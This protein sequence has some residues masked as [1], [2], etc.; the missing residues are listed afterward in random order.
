MTTILPSRMIPTCL[1]QHWKPLCA[2]LRTAAPESEWDHMKKF[3]GPER[4]PNLAKAWISLSC[5]CSSL[6]NPSHFRIYL[7][8]IDDQVW[9]SLTSA[10]LSVS[11]LMTFS[12]LVSLHLCSV[13]SSSSFIC[14]PLIW[15]CTESCTWG[16]QML[17]CSIYHAHHNHPHHHC[18]YPWWN[19]R[20]HLVL[21]LHLYKVLVFFHNLLFSSVHLLNKSRCW[22][23]LKIQGW[24]K[25]FEPD[26]QK[27]EELVKSITKIQ[28]NFQSLSSTHLTDD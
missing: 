8:P 1:P 20:Y 10:N 16:L 18:K 13:F 19:D 27:F 12:E 21:P 24:A 3:S 9:K 28:E 4:D 11:E 23:E 6:A 15:F 26:Q 22:S 25:S 17:L 14:R 7:L 2:G 5:P